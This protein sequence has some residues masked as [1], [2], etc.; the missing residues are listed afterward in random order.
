MPVGLMVRVA[1]VIVVLDVVEM[2]GPAHARDMRSSS[3][4]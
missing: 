2:H 3:R 1:P 4:R